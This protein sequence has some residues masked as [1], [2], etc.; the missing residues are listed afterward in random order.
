MRL[1]SFDIE[2]APFED[3]KEYENLMPDFE[4]RAGTKDPEKIQA[5]IDEKKAK[6]LD[7]VCL[8]PTTSKI[9]AIGYARSDSAEPVTTITEDEAGILKYFW[10]C[11]STHHSKSKFIGHNIKHF[12]LP[13]IIH[14]SRILGLHDM[15]PLCL[16]VIN[17]DTKDFW[18]SFVD[19]MDVYKVFPYSKERVSLDE[20]AKGYKLAGKNGDGASF[21]KLVRSGK[22]EKARK[23]LENDVKLPL[24]IAER[25]WLHTGGDYSSRPVVQRGD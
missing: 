14:R 23:Y 18:N 25:T 5:Q 10:Q 16:T 6:W 3:E 9:I 2:T 1:I 7:S 20:Y 24:Q 22:I 12:D 19:M 17:G 13:F 8:S 11:Y 21:H 15:M 4:G